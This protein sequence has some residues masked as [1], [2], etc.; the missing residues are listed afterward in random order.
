M[1]AS[2]LPY[3]VKQQFLDQIKKNVGSYE[4]DRMV[5][6]IGEDG[7][8]DLAI[9]NLQDS[10]RTQVEQKGFLDRFGCLI[11]LIVGA[12]VYLIWGWEVVVTLFF[13]SL[14]WLGPWIIG[15]IGEAWKSARRR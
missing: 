12:S 2:E 8:V 3:D 7:L 6:S 11:V 4:Y 13:V 1:K 5:D 14:P 10:S 15:T 9:Q